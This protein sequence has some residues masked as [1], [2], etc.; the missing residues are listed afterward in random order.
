M[1]C[2]SAAF[3][4]Q[5]RDVVMTYIYY[6]L[7]SGINL[8]SHLH[9][10]TSKAVST[11][12]NFSFRADGAIRRRI[13]LKMHLY[14]L[15]QGMGYVNLC[16]KQVGHGVDISKYK[17]GFSL[18]FPLISIHWRTETEHRLIWDSPNA[19][20]LPFLSWMMASLWLNT[21]SIRCVLTS[22][23]VWVCLQRTA[24]IRTAN[25]SWTQRLCWA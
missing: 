17:G 7:A 24:A 6:P 10:R 13:C 22:T 14:Q 5:Y 19:I 16:R 3:S 2:D 9:E 1:L 21:M 15:P 18:H 12:W 4:P 8:Q 25:V 20:K 23:L 11:A